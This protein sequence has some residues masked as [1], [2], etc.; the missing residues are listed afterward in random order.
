MFEPESVFDK[1]QDLFSYLTSILGIL[2]LVLFAIGVFDVALQMAQLLLSGK[3]TNVSNIL[4]V[5]DTVLLLMIVLAV[6]RDL[7]SYI[8]GR[9]LLYVIVQVGIIAVVRNII[10]TIASNPSSNIDT[11]YFSASSLL[12]LTGLFIGYYIIEKYGEVSNTDRE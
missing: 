4:G 5:I 8:R 10:I 3:F 9:N 6:F 2:L 1:S 11:I 12:L 7:E